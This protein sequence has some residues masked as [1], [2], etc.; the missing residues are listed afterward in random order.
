MYLAQSSD[1][2]CSQA[3]FYITLLN[4]IIEHNDTDI[5]HDIDLAIDEARLVA[6]G[7]KK[8]FSVNNNYYF[9][10]TLLTK[11]KD[12]LV[13]MDSKDHEEYP[14]ETYQEILEILE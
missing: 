9:I 11:F 5:K 7:T 14:T 6:K 1:T 8:I 12:K 4:E 10:I 3:P 13:E 2:N